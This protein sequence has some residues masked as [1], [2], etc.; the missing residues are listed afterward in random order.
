M[1]KKIKFSFLSY[2]SGRC[3]GTLIAVNLFD[4]SWTGEWSQGLPEPSVLLGQEA[5]PLCS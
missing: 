4:Q 1:K 2:L 3:D 5:G